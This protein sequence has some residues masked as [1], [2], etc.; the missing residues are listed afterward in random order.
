MNDLI[1][2]DVK[3]IIWQQ[4]RATMNGGLVYRFECGF[5]KGW[6]EWVK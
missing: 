1:T 2:K 4:G 3:S 6:G 5:L